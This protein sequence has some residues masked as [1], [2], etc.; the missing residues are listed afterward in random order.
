MKKYILIFLIFSIQ[1]NAQSEEKI[2]SKFIKRT[3]TYKNN[4]LPYRL[5]IPENNNIKPLPLVLCLHGAGE[6]GSDNELQIKYHRLATS[7]ADSINQI[8]YPCYVVAPQC[9]EG[10][11]WVDVEWN[12]GSYSIEKVP[13]SNELETV[14]DLIDKLK[15]EFKIDLNRIYV[16]GLSMGGYATWDLITRFPNKFAAAIPMS[17][18]GDSS[19][20]KLIKNIPI[21]VFHGKLDGTVPVSGSRQM[22]EA[23]EK[24]GEN[25]I[26]TQ[27]LSP[28]TID[29]FIDKKNKNFYTEYPNGNHVIWAE[30]YDNPQ[31]FKWVFSQSKESTKIQQLEIPTSFELY[32]NY[33]NP[34]NPT[35]TI[36]YSIPSVILRQAMSADRQAKDD[37]VTLSLSKGDNLVTLKVYDILGREVATLVNEYQKPGTY[38]IEFRAHSYKLSSGVYFYKLQAGNNIQI[39]RMLL[40]K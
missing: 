18:G 14:V 23:L 30:S 31:L 8:K 26:R 19:K 40:L 17:G 33:P 6:R 36:K 28:Q 21:W 25:F 5:F 12:A 34:F 39:K 3:H 38:S 15:S 24:I 16:T 9:P 1:L 10:E 7:W 35:T 20:V 2:I 22:I 29:Y 4:S 37:N 11:K 27:Y 32:Q 13:I